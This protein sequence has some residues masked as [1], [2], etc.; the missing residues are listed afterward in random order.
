MFSG[1]LGHFPGLKNCKHHCPPE[2]VKVVTVTD[3][4]ILQECIIMNKLILF[5]VNCANVYVPAPFALF[6]FIEQRNIM[7]VIPHTIRLTA[8]TVVTDSMHI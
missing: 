6:T 8:P 4:C 5:N 7:I 1:T 3:L 2:V